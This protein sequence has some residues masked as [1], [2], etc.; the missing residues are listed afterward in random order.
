MQ[1]IGLLLS[2]K[3]PNYGTMLQAF[4]TQYIV[5]SLGAQ[6]ELIDYY[7]DRFNKHYLLDYGFF[8]FLIDTY[9]SKRKKINREKCNDIVFQRNIEQRKKSCLEFIQNRLHSIKKIV[10]YRDLKKYSNSCSAILIGSDQKWTP[11][12]S[13]GV[14]SSL[15]FVSKETRTISY[16]TSLGVSDYPK[17]YWKTSRKV[18]ERIDYLSVRENTGA[19]I[20]KEVCQNKINVE[21]VVDPTYLITK[22]EWEKLFPIEQKLKDK[23]LFCYFLGNNVESKKSA[24]QYADKHGYKLV[25]V[26]SN[27]SFSD[28]DQTYADVLLTGESPDSFI[29]WIRGAECIFTD[30]FH[31]TAFSV[32]NEK[33]VY[34]FYRKNTS[35][36]HQR[37]SRIDDILSLWNISNRL[38][39]DNSIDWP[40]YIENP[41]DYSKVTPIVLSERDRSLNFIKEAI[42]F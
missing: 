20:I 33:Q 10:G 37:H 34:V 14:D 29:N 9:Q 26:L 11:G 12:F 2:Y 5:E 18:W 4:A 24:R 21:V 3:H 27:E 13:F 16:A 42:S 19:R 39:T 40:E 7:S 36:K 8:R 22:S 17:R 6:T 15:R 28:I 25:S 23:Y 31:G 41:I 30:S 38:I 35:V 32:I 1:K